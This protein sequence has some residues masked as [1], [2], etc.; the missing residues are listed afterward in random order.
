MPMISLINT[1]SIAFR[2]AGLVLDLVRW[3]RRIVRNTIA[4]FREQ[5]TSE[6]F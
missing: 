5:D 3:G 6:V 4:N 2:I 1:D